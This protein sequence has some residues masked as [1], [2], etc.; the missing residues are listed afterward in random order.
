MA[1]VS[2]KILQGSEGLDNRRTVWWE[3]I[4]TGD[5]ITPFQPSGPLVL[6]RV[7]FVPVTAGGATLTFEA[8]QDG[9]NFEGVANKAET[10]IS[11]TAVGSDE[12]S[13]TA[14]YVK[15][16]IASGTSDEWHVYLTYWS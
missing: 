4:S 11:K 6:A 8:S 16:A 12:I 15:P 14:N 2:A 3:S 5:T 9:T 1:T 13:C 7:Q 10:A